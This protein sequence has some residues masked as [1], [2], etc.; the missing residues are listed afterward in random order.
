MYLIGQGKCVSEDLVLGVGKSGT[1]YW[2]IG[3]QEKIQS[4]KHAQGK[5]LYFLL[6]FS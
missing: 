6:T 1:R 2:A 3:Y 4:L 5:Y